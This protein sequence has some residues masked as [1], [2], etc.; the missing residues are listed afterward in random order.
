VRRARTVRVK[1]GTVTV[2]QG[3]A[4]GERLV[5]AAHAFGFFTRQAPSA[6]LVSGVTGSRVVRDG[7]V[8]VTVR[9][10]A[11]LGGIRAVVQVQAVCSRV[12]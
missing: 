6:S 2:V 7:R 10:D 4:A 8:R 9:G 11:E 3:C 12:R 5:G 1:P